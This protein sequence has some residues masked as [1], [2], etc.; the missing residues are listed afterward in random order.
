MALLV[1]PQN[2]EAERATLGSIL[3]DPE[4]FEHVIEIISEHDFYDPRH[5]AIFSSMVSLFDKGMPIDVVTISNEL[6]NKDGKAK[7]ITTDFLSYLVDSVPISS[8]ATYYADIVKKKSLLR[9]VINAASEITKE[10]YD[11]GKDP[12]EVL[13]FAER[14]VY[15]ISEK[16]LTKSFVKLDVVL[17]KVVEQIGNMYDRYKK[18]L[19]ANLGIPSGFRDLDEIFTGFNPTDYIVIAARPGMGKTSFAL[20]LANNITKD[21]DNAVAI[22]SLEM[23]NEQLLYRYFSMNSNIPLSQVKRGEMSDP[24]WKNALI[25]TDGMMGRNIWLD[26]DPYLTP[27]IL[28]TKLRKVLREA[29][30]KVV[31][32]DYLQLMTTDKRNFD[33][34]QQEISEI[35]RN[36]KLIAKEFNVCIV[37]LSQLSRAVEQRDDKKPKL[38]D[39][40]ESGA[41]EQDA[42]VVMFLYRPSY[43]TKKDDDK[44]AE[45]I[46]GKQRNGPIGSVT[47]GFDP[48]YTVFSDK[49]I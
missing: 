27:R 22:F 37:V 24:I 29:D 9:E 16:H 2:L 43:Y 35:S 44:S 25:K 19:P 47:L 39:L 31:F 41:I 14:V 48:K 30:I 5:R 20:T 12:D 8:N 49:I 4:Q 23:S 13:D 38:S 17:E 32:I 34:R 46:V 10:A 7:D 18:G 11:D 1:P 26:D 21:S 28:R 42:D 45:I 40:R 15:N 6:K 33:N 3:I 36:I